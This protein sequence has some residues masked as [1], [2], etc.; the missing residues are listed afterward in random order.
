MLSITEKDEVVFIWRGAARAPIR[1]KLNRRVYSVRAQISDKFHPGR[2][3]CGSMAAEKPV[4]DS[5]R[6]RSS[7][8]G[9]GRQNA[10]DVAACPFQ[11]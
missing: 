8:S 10:A 2:S 3:T 5:N 4:F 9:H 11:P 6:G 1:V 7:L